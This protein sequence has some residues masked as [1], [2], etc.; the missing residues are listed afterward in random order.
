MTNTI[1]ERGLVLTP[2]KAKGLWS[3]EL[4]WTIHG[5]DNKYLYSEPLY[6]C[7]A[8]QV[9][10]IVQLN[11]PEKILAAEM[12]QYLDRH[13]YTLSERRKHWPKK[14]VFHAYGVS[15]KEI[16]PEPI[17][18]SID[19]AG[20]GLAIVSLQDTQGNIRKDADVA[21]MDNKK[22]IF[23]HALMHRFF[24]MK[25]EGKLHTWSVEDIWTL[26]KRMIGEM[27]RRKLKH[28]PRDDLDKI[29][30]P[31]LNEPIHKLQDDKLLQ[32][33]WTYSQVSKK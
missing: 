31:V 12:D 13:G 10:G 5:N 28:V 30:V 32:L 21:E 8:M 6:L 14:V 25:R 15:W 33:F 2:D 19:Y 16:Y 11:P 4:L 24:I 3:Q 23:N 26:H 20:G 17:P 29:S 22:L 1:I 27:Q 7:D 9:Y 18:A